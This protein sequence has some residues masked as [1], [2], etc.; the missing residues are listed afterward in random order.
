MGPEEQALLAWHREGKD[1]SS[2]EVRE[3]TAALKN[4]RD[5]YS[6]AEAWI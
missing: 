2:L 6:R 1:T 3:R 5:V 4:V